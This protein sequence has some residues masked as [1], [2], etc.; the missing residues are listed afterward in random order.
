MRGGLL[1]PAFHPSWIISYPK[2]SGKIVASQKDFYDGFGRPV[3]FR[4]S[5]ALK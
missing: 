4:Q 2:P 3:Y 5:W 1:G